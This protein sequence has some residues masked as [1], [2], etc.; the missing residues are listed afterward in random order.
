MPRTS[1]VRLLLDKFG[2]A[3]RPGA[4]TAKFNEVQDVE[5]LMREL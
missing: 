4:L 5:V 2:L 3:G 1:G